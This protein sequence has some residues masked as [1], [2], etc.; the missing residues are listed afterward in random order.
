MATDRTEEA[1]RRTALPL[2]RRGRAPRTVA[3]EVGRSLAWVYKW[4][5]RFAREGWAGL[6]S[7]SRVPDHPARR[8]PDTTRQAIRQ[9]RSA[10]EAEAAQPGT[11][12]YGGDH[13]I[14]GRLRQQRVSPLPSLSTIEREVR[15]A[16]MPRPS[17]PPPPET[18][19]PRLRPTQPHELVQADIVPKHLRGGQRVACFNA[20]DGV[21]RYP[22]A[23]Q[24][25]TERAEEAVAFLH[26]VWQRVGIPT[27]TQV[28]NEGCFSGGPTHP[29]V[30]GQVLRAALAVGTE[31]VF[32]PVRPPR[33]RGPWSASTWT[34]GATCAPR[35]TWRRRSRT[36]RPSWSATAPARTTPPWEV[37]RLP[38][39]TWRIA[40]PGFPPAI[41]RR[42]A[43]H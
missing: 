42:G 29:Y 43:C 8:I 2:L 33:A 15:A 21:S 24:H 18:T 36:R 17:P 4:R 30:L 10:L 7:R 26:H 25:P 22:T 35:R 1:A 19:Y 28:D 20:L 40:S 27:H 31:L 9:A 38:I 12:C 5:A 32:S 39:A 16:G 37:R 14:L 11:L 3:A 41:R 13:A 23:Q 6:Q 34:T